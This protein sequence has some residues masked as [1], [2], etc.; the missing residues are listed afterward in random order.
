[1]L[2]IATKCRINEL[3]APKNCQN[4]QYKRPCDNGKYRDEKALLKVELYNLF[5][6]MRQVAHFTYEFIVIHL[7]RDG[8]GRISIAIMNWLLSKK[9]LPPIYVDQKCKN[10]YYSSLS[11]IDLEK[12][13][14]P[15]VMFI[16]K[17]IIHTMIGLHQ[18]L[19]INEFE[20]DNMIC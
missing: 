19:F 16:E 17:R 14:T 12:D 10:E 18:Y 11:K 13:I 3:S 8:N 4:F 2:T 9:Q 6:I 15:F 1:M 7:F 20:E 5:L